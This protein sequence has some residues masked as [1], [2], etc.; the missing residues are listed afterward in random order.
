MRFV[1]AVWKLL[2][3]IKDA[4]VLL[5]MLLFFGVLYA[6]LSARPAAIGDGVL[7]M[8]LDG[9]LVEQASRPD[10]LAALAGAGDVTHE[11]ELRD[12]IA[13]L[14]TAKDDDRV[15]AIVPTLASGRSLAWSG[16]A[17]DSAGGF[18][19]ASFGLPQQDGLLVT[20]VSAGS[21]PALSGRVK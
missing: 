1:K 2:V 15:K 17:L 4:L 5:F 9:V 18:D 21:A 19:L 16:M 7:A 20:N 11:F 6:A 13:A 10:A 14:D 3:G 12:L 8:D